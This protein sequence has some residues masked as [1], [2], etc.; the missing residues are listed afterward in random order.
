MNNGRLLCQIVAIAGL[1]SLLVSCSQNTSLPTSTTPTIDSAHLTAFAKNKQNYPTNNV[2]PTPSTANASNVGYAPKNCPVI[3]SLHSERLSPAIVPLAG[4]SPVWATL[5][6]G[7]VHLAGDAYDSNGGWPLK[8]VWEIGPNY[9]RAVMLRAT[10]LLDNKPI[11]FDMTP[12]HQITIFP[13][14]DPQ[15]PGHPASVIGS[16]WKEWGSDLLIPAA[17]CY[18]VDATWPGGHWRINFA[19]GL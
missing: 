13:V 19:A 12:S 1:V 11:K 3:S 14:L 7:I 4:I 16:N 8:I 17:G 10:N 5:S 15:S 9:N 18:A 2:N 6:G